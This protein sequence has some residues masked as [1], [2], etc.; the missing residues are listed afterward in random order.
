MGLL[1]VEQ[2][3]TR[4]RHPVAAQIA[5]HLESLVS[6]SEKAFALHAAVPV[7]AVPVNG[8]SIATDYD[9]VS[10]ERFLIVHGTVSITAVKPRTRGLADTQT[11]DVHRD[12]AA[13][14]SS[15]RGIHKSRSR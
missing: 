14:A 7:N 9:E 4:V 1:M 10:L 15:A 12:Y 11:V 3:L 8:L 13:K 6:L 2:R 5:R